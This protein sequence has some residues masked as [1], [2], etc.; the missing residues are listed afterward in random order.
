MSEKRVEFRLDADLYREIAA[1]AHAEDRTIPRTIVRL[2]RERVEKERAKRGE[3]Q[4]AEE[5]Q[6]LAELEQQRQ[7]ARPRFNAN[8]VPSFGLGSR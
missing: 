3:R 5:A 2:I 1:I 7:A 6:A 8:A 4:K